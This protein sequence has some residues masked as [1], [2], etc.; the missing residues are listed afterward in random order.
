MLSYIYREKKMNID[1]F[2]ESCEKLKRKGQF[3]PEKIE[4]FEGDCFLWC[5]ELQ[6]I[7]D[8]E[9]LFRQWYRQQYK[10]I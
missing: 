1:D 10:V 4:Y 8:V 3:D 9:D 5:E 2:S 6:T 7:K